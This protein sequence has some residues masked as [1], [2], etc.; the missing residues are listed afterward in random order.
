M[1]L[2]EC[3]HPRVIAADERGE[4]A[5]DRRF[6][7]NIGQDRRC[8]PLFH[9]VTASFGHQLSAGPRVAHARASDAESQPDFRVFTDDRDRVELGAGWKRVSQNSGNVYVSAGCCD[10]APQA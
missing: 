5:I 9:V 6:Q 4:T 10:A 3:A 2:A 8:R 7:L 1:G